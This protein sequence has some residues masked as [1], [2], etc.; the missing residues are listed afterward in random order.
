MFNPIMVLS[1]KLTNALISKYT[2]EYDEAE[3][4]LSIYME[5]PVGIGEHPQHLQEM[6]GLVKKMVEASDNR[7]MIEKWKKSNCNHL[8]FP[9]SG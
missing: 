7:K 8:R 6:D 5:N 9:D 2:S 3:A 1:S 4:T